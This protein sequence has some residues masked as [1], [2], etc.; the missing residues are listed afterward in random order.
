VD[1]LVML[2]GS[3]RTQAGTMP[4]LLERLVDSAAFIC[5]HPKSGTSLIASLL[6]AHP[7]VLVYPE[8]TLFFRNTVPSIQDLPYEQQ[9]SAAKEWILRIFHW[10]PEISHPSQRDY[11]DRDYSAID[12]DAVS[13]TFDELVGV[14]SGKLYGL[15]PCAILAYGRV[16]GM[17]THQTKGWMEKSPYNEAYADTIFEIWPDAKC[18]HILRDPRDNYASYVRKHSNW[19]PKVFAFSWLQSTERGWR[20]LKK[21]GPLRYHIIQY[22]TLVRQPEQTLINL[23]SFLEIDFTVGMLVPTRAG[24]AW[25]GNSMFADEFHTISDK[26]IGRYQKSLSP[27]IIRELEKLL[28]RECQRLGYPLKSPV[29]VIDRTVSAGVRARWRHLPRRGSSRGEVEGS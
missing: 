27:E 14:A 20:N 8:E 10:D 12:Y 25:R 26:S 17:L 21:Y 19:S 7:Q 2:H 18:V 15:L 24:K 6:D 16:S 13:R 22:E 5:G 9:V 11:P 3:V 1:G 29:G 23:A 28:F 4:Y